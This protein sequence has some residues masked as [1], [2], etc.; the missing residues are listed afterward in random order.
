MGVTT[1]FAMDFTSYFDDI[2]MHCLLSTY[3]S[4]N[5][6]QL[7]PIKI[8]ILTSIPPLLAQTSPNVRKQFFTPRCLH[9]AVT[10][11]VFDVRRSRSMVDV[12]KFRELHESGKP[13]LTCGAVPPLP[14]PFCSNHS[15]IFIS[16][17][18]SITTLLCSNN[19]TIR[20]IFAQ[21]TT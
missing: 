5:V 21:E 11:I 16:K 17:L 4:L 13:L 15:Q 14:W 20:S 18:H 8:L 19:T 12:E 1:S 3:M 6:N 2:K 10:S 9:H 7:S